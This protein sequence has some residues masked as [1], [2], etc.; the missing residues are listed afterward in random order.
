MTGV[1]RRRVARLL[2]AFALCAAACGE[3]P[4]PAAPTTSRATWVLEP[5]RIALGQ[6]AVIELAVVTPPEHQVRPFAAK[7]EIPGFWLL[8]TEA[9]P[10]EKQASRWIHRTRLRVRARDV[11]RFVWPGGHVQVEGTG[12]R[13]ESLSLDDLTL[14]VVSQ[15]SEYP[16]RLAPFELRGV[17]APA[18]TRSTL[19]AAAGGAG[20]ALAAVAGVVLVR[21]RLGRRRPLSQPT[22]APAA[23]PWIESRVDFTRARSQEPREAAHT[24]AVA[25]RRYMGR[26]FGANTLARTTEELDAAT[27]PF[28]ATSRWPAFVAILR[29][30]DEFRFRPGTDTPV[31]ADRVR[32]L[33]DEA[34][35]FVE[36]TIPPGSRS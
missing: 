35:A 9:L 15:F 10:V 36:D 29:G 4:P 21:R 12:D 13:V 2:A 1:A 30:L 25:L 24:V 19:V 6:V 16:E 34:D 31:V 5:P 8:E 17:G 3:P 18:G 20:V 11:G 33:V 23:P 7:G 32:A 26:R 28:T 14:D 27:P 22:P